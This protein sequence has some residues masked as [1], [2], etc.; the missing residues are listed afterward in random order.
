MS[1][2]ENILNSLSLKNK[3][4]KWKYIIT[5]SLPIIILN[6]ILFFIEKYISPLAKNSF[7][8]KIADKLTIFS[9]ML[10]FLLS[11]FVSTDLSA[12]L[13]LFSVFCTT[14]KHVSNPQ[15]I[16]RETNILT[17]TVILFFMINFTSVGFSP[18]PKLALVGFSKLIIYMLAYFV[19]IV[20]IDSFKDI[21]MIFYTILISSSI[22]SFY[23]V[24]QFYIKVEPYQGALWDD[25]NAVNEKVTR[26]Y[27][28]LKNPNLLAGYLI[29]TI[30][31]SF[32]L[33]MLEK[34]LLQKIVLL[35]LVFV[36]L[37]SLYWTY[38]RA[39]WLAMIG[40]FGIFIISL[41]LMNKKITIKRK[42]IYLG[43]GL[44]V[45]L[46]IGAIIKSPATFERLTS[47][48][49]VR[50]HSSNSFRMNVWL[51]CIDIF[52][53]NFIIGIGPGNTVFNSIY[54]LYMFS[55]F[56]ALSAYNIFLETGVETGIIGLIIF[57]VMLFSHFL[58][59][60][61]TLYSNLNYE[62]KV[63]SMACLIGFSGLLV[64]GLFDTIWYRPQV[65]IQLWL[66]LAIITL[67]S[68]DNFS[69]NEL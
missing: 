1:G 49:T 46:F 6:K 41:F 39:G 33:F 67:V 3:E 18:Y 44:A 64:Q 19:F 29:P 66:I 12:L 52:K 42:Y 30:S 11:P 31:F 51:A 62:N 22:M 36:Q 63:I 27:S 26:V 40:M 45:L 35:F 24:Y 61:W 2:I 15:S 14:L 43:L 38:S 56:K 58:R 9:I 55:G 32:A 57:C 65:H 7:T 68:K 16:Y 47:I 53:D 17:A 10:L 25:P 8:L 54:P 28:F 69:K 48:F 13:V 37:I 5:N 60:L 20:N 34:K 21:K 4:D 23:A 59:G 50:G